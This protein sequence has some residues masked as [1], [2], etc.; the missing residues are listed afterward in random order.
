MRGIRYCTWGTQVGS[1]AIRG[2]RIGGG[3]QPRSG[4]ME[5]M[6][7]P[8]KRVRGFYV[9][10]Y[11]P[12]GNTVPRTT[13]YLTTFIHLKF[14]LAYYKMRAISLFALVA[15]LALVAPSATALTCSQAKQQ[16]RVLHALS[17]HSR[18]ANMI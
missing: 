17:L 6:G 16:V 7:N 8:R 3:A 13:A 18:K 12:D 5:G 14:S 9:P 2:E 10:A 11:S 1:H 4:H 15:V